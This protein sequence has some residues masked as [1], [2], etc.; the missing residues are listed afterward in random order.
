V[1]HKFPWENIQLRED[2]GEGVSLWLVEGVGDEDIDNELQQQSTVSMR[3]G[4]QPMV[5]AEAHPRLGI[6]G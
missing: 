1:L 6:K 5:S 2:G 4:D 3:R